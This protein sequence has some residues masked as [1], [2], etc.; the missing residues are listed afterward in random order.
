MEM[1]Q[2]ADSLDIDVYSMPGSEE[3]LGAW[4]D[5]P[6]D[7]SQ[8]EWQEAAEVAFDRFLEEYTR[9]SQG[10][11]FPEAAQEFSGNGNATAFVMYANRG[12]EDFS[13]EP[14]NEINNRY[15]QGGMAYHTPTTMNM[16]LKNSLL[17]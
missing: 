3:Y 12:G 6:A 8:E 5:E 16:L 13:E 11:F 7:K 9:P 17:E 2:L 15:N 4:I 1:H 10:R 14:L